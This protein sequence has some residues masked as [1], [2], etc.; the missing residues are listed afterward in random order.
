[1]TPRRIQAID[2][3][4]LLSATVTL[5]T[6][7]WPPVPT[8]P[9]HLVNEELAVDS[10]ALL[11]V[12]MV[13]LYGSSPAGR[14]VLDTAFW[15]GRF[16]DRAAPAA[17]RMTRPDVCLAL[18]GKRSGSKSEIR[19]ACIDLYEMT[20]GGAEPQIGTKGKPGPLYAM[21]GAGVHCWDALAL[22]LAWLLEQGVDG[23]EA[24]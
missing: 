1:M 11:L 9:A 10:E 22:G 20:G 16:F 15:A 21:R 3:G 23:R 5:D 19:R 14:S 17:A 6:R 4:P 24:A 13:T 8:N 18:L 2:P 12:E 7:F